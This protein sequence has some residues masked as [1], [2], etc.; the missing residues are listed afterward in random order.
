MEGL[1]LKKNLK[2]IC[3]YAKSYVPKFFPIFVVF[4]YYLLYTKGKIKKVVI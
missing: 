3:H 1:I 4:F 2:R